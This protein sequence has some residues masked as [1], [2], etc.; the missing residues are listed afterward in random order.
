M[1]LASTLDHG[2]RT[3][4]K[5]VIGKE[6]GGLEECGDWLSEYSK[7][8]IVRKSSLSGKPFYLESKHYPENRRDCMFC[9]N[10]KNIFRAIGNAE[11]PAEDYS[12]IKRSLLEQISGELQK[13]KSLKWNI[14]ELGEH[15]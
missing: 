7:Q 10:S 2:F 8:P 6:I 15:V 3:T 14:Y 12:K 1:D 13:K 5:I 9:F 11:Y 4:C